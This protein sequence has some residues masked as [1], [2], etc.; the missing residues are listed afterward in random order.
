TIVTG[1]VFGAPPDAK[2]QRQAHQHGHRHD[3]HGKPHL[4]VLHGR[5]SDDKEGSGRHTQQQQHRAVGPGQ[6]HYWYRAW[7]IVLGSHPAG[8]TTTIVEWAGL[9]SGPPTACNC[10]AGH[11]CWG[12]RVSSRWGLVGVGGSRRFVIQNFQLSSPL[13]EQP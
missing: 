13:S 12:W 4:Q 3:G 6:A 10:H 2:G 11:Y 1:P 9:P 5:E 8:S 7:A